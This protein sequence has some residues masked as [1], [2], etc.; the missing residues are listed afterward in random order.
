MGSD[1]KVKL[2]SVLY[3]DEQKEADIIEQVESLK[4]RHKLGDFI[5]ACIR[6]CWEN[7]EVFRKAGY[8]LS[9]FGLTD[10]RIK[11]FSNIERQ[12]NEL[13]AK[14]DKIYDLSLKT[15]TLAQFGK[16]LGLEEKSENCLRATFLIQ[17]QVDELS[18]I[19]G[20]S[21][22]NNVWESNKL[23]VTSTK[24]DE[25]LEFIIESYESITLEIK[26]SLNTP[27]DLGHK[28]INDGIEKVVETHT[29]PKEVLKQEVHKEIKVEQINEIETP[30]VDVDNFGG[31]NWDLLENFV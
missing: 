4:N 3:L 11:F 8:S 23:E 10:S 31:D 29:T 9:Q 6:T 7:P 30:E 25:L 2:N 20:L 28:I 12:L 16:R 18:S 14:V 27:V 1:F 26:Q 19:L 24:V 5:T 22:I 13:R 17:R 21:G 15:Y